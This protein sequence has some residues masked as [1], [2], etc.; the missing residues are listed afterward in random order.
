[1]NL[2]LREDELPANKVEG[3]ETKIQALAEIKLK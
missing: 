3:I 2:S 1:M